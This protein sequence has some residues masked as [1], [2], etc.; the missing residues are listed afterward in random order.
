MTVSISA[1]LSVPLQILPAVVFSAVRSVLFPPSHPFTSP[2]VRLK[3]ALT[4][5]RSTDNTKGFLHFGFSQFFS[6]R[7]RV[8]AVM[9]KLKTAQ[10]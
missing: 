10:N 9:M 1:S 2:T 5:R 6:F 3:M 4:E 8:T 7:P